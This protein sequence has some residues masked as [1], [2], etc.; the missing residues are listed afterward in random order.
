MAVLN[1]PQKTEHKPEDNVNF[2]L[3]NKKKQLGT[4]MFGAILQEI[5][6]HALEI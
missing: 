3:E 6:R 1:S 4:D 5:L 2:Y